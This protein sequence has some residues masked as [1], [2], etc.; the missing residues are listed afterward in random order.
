VKDSVKQV[1][2]VHGEQ[3]PASALIQKLAEAGMRRVS[4]PDQ[5]MS[6]EI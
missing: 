5:G 1:Y 6:V 2:L 3:A 4:Y